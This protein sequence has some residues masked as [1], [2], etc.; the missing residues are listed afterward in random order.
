V[1]ELAQVFRRNYLAVFPEG[2]K[3]SESPMIISTGSPILGHGKISSFLH[4]GVFIPYTGKNK[5]LALVK[6][7]SIGLMD[8]DERFLFI[9]DELRNARHLKGDPPLV[10]DE[11]A[12]VVFVTSDWAKD[13]LAALDYIHTKV[14]N[15]R[16]NFFSVRVPKL[17]GEN[18]ERMAYV[19]QVIG[20][21]LGKRFIHHEHDALLLE[22]EN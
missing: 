8:Q 6:Y 4:E 15:M 21:E 3:T 11:A 19:G 9:L 2:A 13:M 14:K 7:C 5:D 20:K 1:K 10:A 12:M 18:N 16:T 22:V 17:S